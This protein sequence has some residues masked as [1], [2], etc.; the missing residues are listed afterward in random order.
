MGSSVG[1]QLAVHNLGQKLLGNGVLDLK[2]RKQELGEPRDEIHKKGRRSHLLILV[3]S[4]GGD[5][6]DLGGRGGDDG[7]GVLGLLGE[8]NGHT[9]RFFN[10]QEEVFRRKKKK[11]IRL[12]FRDL[13]MNCVSESEEEED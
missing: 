1:D 5:D 11:K 3:L 6:I 4:L 8:K 7:S 12:E 10:L 13:L 9:I 2:E